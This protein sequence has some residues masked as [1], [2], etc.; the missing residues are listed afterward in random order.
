MRQEPGSAWGCLAHLGADESVSDEQSRQDAI[1]RRQERMSESIS[2][3][4]GEAAEGKTRVMD[5]G[6]FD[7]LRAQVRNSSGKVRSGGV[8]TE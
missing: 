6:Y 2:R 3:S 7:G 1:E 4:R 8:Q 5:D